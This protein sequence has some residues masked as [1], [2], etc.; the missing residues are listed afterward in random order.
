MASSR[1][2]AKVI[3]SIVF[4]LFAF[5]PIPETSCA[6]YALNHKGLLPAGKTVGN[7]LSV[8]K[9][10]A[11]NLNK[12]KKKKVLSVS[13]N[14]FKKLAENQA[15]ME[16]EADREVAE[17]VFPVAHKV[18]QQQREQ[19]V[20]PEF[21]GTPRRFPESIMKSN[22]SAT[23]LEEDREHD[24]KGMFKPYYDCDLFQDGNAIGQADIKPV[25]IN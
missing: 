20:P 5:G 24:K 13:K 2:W 19:I 16:K 7:S 6:S 8:R 12:Q 22:L 1:T 14:L 3:F 23:H 25:S 21:Q 10:R 17:T 11:S 9:S 4:T 15:E 18:N